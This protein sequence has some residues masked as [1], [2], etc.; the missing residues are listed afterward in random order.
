MIARPLGDDWDLATIEAFAHGEADLV[1]PPADAERITRGHERL[2]SAAIGREVYGL[3]TGVGARRFVAVERTAESCLRLWRAHALQLGEQVDP[4]RTRAAMLVRSIQLA[5]GGS[6]VSLELAAGLASAARSSDLPVLRYGTS[7]GTGD[8]AALAAVAL[9]L[10]ER[11]V[12]FRPSDGLPFMSSGALTY[13][14]AAITL[15]SLSRAL[16]AGIEIT[17]LV[18]RA[19]RS[20]PEHFSEAALAVQH[21]DVRLAAARLR[22]IRGVEPASRVQEPFSVRLA[23]HSH[24]SVT[25]AWKAASETVERGVNAALENPVVLASN[26]IAHVGNF[27]TIE[28]ALAVDGLLRALAHEASLASARLSLL[29]DARFTGATDFLSDGT[30]DATGAMMLEYAASAAVADAR[31]AAAAHGAY[32]ISVS[33][34]AE[35]HAPFTAHAIRRLARSEEAYRTILACLGVA[36]GRLPGG[37]EGAPGLVDCS[38]NLG[39]RDLSGEVH[40][41]L[42]RLDSVRVS[43]P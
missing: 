29:L 35:E 41:V 42:E 15:R 30:A 38:S 20:T 16:D 13:A 7:L 21:H 10:A 27:Y 17:G 40:A 26:D 9:H 24:G 3:S 11:G 34:G 19:V 23:P 22:R 4:V 31:E 2:L 43:V 5:R 33:Q 36:L 18:A 8:I 14:D 39:D 25:R 6:G 12:T 1:L 32:G 37:V 28:L